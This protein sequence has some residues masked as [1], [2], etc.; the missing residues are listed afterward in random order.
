[1]GNNSKGTF[2]HHG[3]QEGAV[4]LQSE[5][6]SHAYRKAHVFRDVKGREERSEKDSTFLNFLR[7]TLKKITWALCT[8]PSSYISKYFKYKII[9][10]E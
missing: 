4:Q 7:V 3:P 10:P 6:L 1:M 9:L 5:D 8:L 2:R